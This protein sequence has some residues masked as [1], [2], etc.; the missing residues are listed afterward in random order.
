METRAARRH[1]VSVSAEPRP[2]RL[3]RLARR[4]ASSSSTEA[5]T[6]SAR[7]ARS[8]RPPTPV[9][10]ATTSPAPAARP[11][12]RSA[13]VSP[14]TAVRAGSTPSVAH[15]WRTMSGAGLTAIPSSAQTVASMRSVDAQGGQGPFGRIAVVGR[16]HGDPAAAGAQPVEQRAQVGRRVGPTRPGRARARPPRAPVPHRPRSGRSPRA[17]RAS[18]SRRRAIGVAASPPPARTVPVTG[19]TPSIA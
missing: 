14:T 2:L 10:T 19:S 4:P 5:I 3:P 11:I 9:S 13:A 16:R 18:R 15:R 1:A 17:P 8:A 12:C 6:A 7:G